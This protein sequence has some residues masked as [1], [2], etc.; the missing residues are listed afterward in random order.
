MPVH[1]A[2]V[3]L[4][5][6]SPDRRLHAQ[7][8]EIVPTDQLAAHPFGLFAIR[9]AEGHRPAREHARENLV[10]IPQVLVHRIRETIRRTARR[11]R[12]RPLRPVHAHQF[13]GILHG[14]HAQQDLIEQ[15][16]D[17]RI[18]TDPK[19]EAQHGN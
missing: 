14:K 17:R 5:K 8:V 19:R 15:S 18:R 9:E 3:V 12:K 7:D 2:I 13:L 11:S 1:H 10:L 6:G 4:S 16:E